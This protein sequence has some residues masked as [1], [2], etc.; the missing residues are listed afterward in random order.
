MLSRKRRV[1]CSGTRLSRRGL[2]DRRHRPLAAR[3]PRV[4]AEGVDL[5]LLQLGPDPRIDR[6]QGSMTAVIEPA[7]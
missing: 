4:G 3:N 2:D 7:E 6:C 1:S 5:V